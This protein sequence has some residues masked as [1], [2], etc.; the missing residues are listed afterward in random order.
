MVETDIT[1]RWEQGIRHHP[2]SIEILKAIMNNG[3]KTKEILK[4]KHVVIDVL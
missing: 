4:T 3:W 1:K 2:K